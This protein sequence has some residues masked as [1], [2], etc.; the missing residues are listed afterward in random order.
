[1]LLSKYS[2]DRNNTIASL[3]RI[4]YT[5][6]FLIAEYFGLRRVTE[7]LASCCSASIRSKGHMP[8]M[9]AVILYRVSSLYYIC[10][11]YAFY[12]Q[13]SQN[14]LTNAN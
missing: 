12:T 1:M 5:P 14:T 3:F 6:D 9:S 4:Q 2:L 8:W 13:S 10:D 7:D 11:L